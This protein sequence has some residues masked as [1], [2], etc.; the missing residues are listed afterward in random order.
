MKE[1]SSNRDE[2]EKQ[3]NYRILGMNAIQQSSKMA[4]AGKVKEAQVVSKAWNRRMR[5]QKNNMEQE[6][7]FNVYNKHMGAQYNMVQ[8]ECEEYLSDAEEG[9]AKPKSK[10]GFF[11]KLG[12]KIS[13]NLVG[14]K[15]MNSNKFK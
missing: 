7:A 5:S 4:R 3:A 1:I 11:G 8:E 14:N 2:L 9:E 6:E 10:K 12:D 13:T 15:K